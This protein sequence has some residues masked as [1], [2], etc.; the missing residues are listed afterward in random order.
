MHFVKHGGYMKRI[1]LIIT[2]LMLASSLTAGPGG[3]PLE[4]LGKGT[5]I[6]EVSMG[7][8]GTANCPDANAVYWN[9]AYLDSINKNEVYMSVETLFGGGNFDQISYTNPV[10]T[11]GGIG[12]YVTMLNYPAYD[13]VDSDGNPIGDQGSMKDIVAGL[14]Y[15]KT[16][17][18]GVQAGLAGKMIIKNIDD[19]AYTGFNAD[20]ALFKPITDIFDVGLVFKNIIPVSIK[21][22]TLEENF[23]PSARFGALVKLFD[24]QLKIAFDAEK[25]F[26]NSPVYVY[27]GAECCIADMFFIRAGINTTGDTINYGGGAGIS[28]KDINFDYGLIVNDLALSHKFALS[29]RFG[30]YD[31]SLKAEPDVFSPVGGNRRTYIRISA[32]MK[33]TVYKW[34]IEITNGLGDVVKSWMG[35]GEPPTEEI[36]DGLKQDGLPMP[37]AEYRATLTVIDEND[38]A[39][40]SDQIKIKIS[41]AGTINIPMMGD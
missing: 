2:A 18:W 3:L 17:W 34:K 27:G 24:K 32:K 15:G 40:S 28:W 4:V 5:G 36:W 19:T 31:L 25:Y 7:E 22:S 9:P 26:I 11:I 16:L 41:N 6:R 14:G 30:G 23:E 37:E 12:A 39:V 35:A 21:Y 13:R 33:Y 38:V 8:A 29:Y 10:G 20:A 1:L